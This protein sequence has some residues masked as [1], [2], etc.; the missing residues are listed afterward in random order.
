[1][2]FIQLNV[3]AERAFGVLSAWRTWDDP[4]HGPGGKRSGELKFWPPKGQD[5]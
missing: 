1:M 4:N 2:L 3:D 5:P